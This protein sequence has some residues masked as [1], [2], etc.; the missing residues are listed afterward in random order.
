MQAA[1]IYKNSS[2]PD[3]IELVQV[4]I[5]IAMTRMLDSLALPRYRAKV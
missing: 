1:T 2:E 3:S 4:I 5:R